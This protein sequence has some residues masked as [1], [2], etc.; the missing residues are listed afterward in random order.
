MQALNTVKVELS[1]PIVQLTADHSPWALVL[2]FQDLCDLLSSY[3]NAKED[4]QAKLA[5]DRQ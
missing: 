3:L 2:Y 4:H 1:K 5:L